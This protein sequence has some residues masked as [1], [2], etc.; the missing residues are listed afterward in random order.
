M[1]HERIAAWAVYYVD[2]TETAA[3]VLGVLAVESDAVAVA[4]VALGHDQPGAA[5]I[6]PVTGYID[7]SYCHRWPWRDG[8]L[9]V[10]PVGLPV[11]R[12][13]GEAPHAA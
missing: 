3:E 8:T 11:L 13:V 10:A 6:K 5:V 7:G 12:F 4:E 1:L 9:Y 2:T